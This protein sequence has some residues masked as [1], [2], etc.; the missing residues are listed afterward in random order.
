MEE[1]S[2][3]Y[4]KLGKKYGIKTRIAH[5]HLA[6][7]NNPS[8]VKRMYNSVLKVGLR[9]YATD[10]LLAVRTQA[11]IFSATKFLKKQ[12]QSFAECD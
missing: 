10:F 7:V 5:A 9:R 6:Y 8:F 2:A 3:L 1:W 11:G 4:C 12:F